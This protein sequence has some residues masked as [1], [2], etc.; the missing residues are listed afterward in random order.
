MLRTSLERLF[1]GWRRR[2]DATALAKVFDR[3][4]PEL[5]KLAVHLVRDPVEA[6]DVLQATY[7]TAIE[8]AEHYDKDRPL[9]PWLV[10]ILVNQ[11]RTVRKKKG[12]AD[13]GG[14]AL[15]LDPP[16]SAEGPGQRAAAEEFST[17]LVKALE[18]LPAPYREV[19][20]MHLNEGHKPVEIARQ[21]GRAPGTVRMQM[22]RGMTL[23]RRALPASFAAGAA[24]SGFPTR[25]MP[26]IRAEVL[27]RGEALVPATAAAGGGATLA[28]SMA[29]KV[30]A[31]GLV[32]SALGLWLGWPGSADEPLT[33]AE[34]RTRTDEAAATAPLVE[35]AESTRRD[36][37]GAN[38]TAS[39]TADTATATRERIVLRG[40]VVGLAAADSADVQLEVRGVARFQ[41][42]DDVVAKGSTRA[43][44]SFEIDVTSL[45]RAVEG[46]LPLHGLVVTAE[47]ALYLP[48][49][50]NV[51]LAPGVRE[52]E[53][54]IELSPAGV[55]RG[56]LQL[57]ASAPEVRVAAL[58]LVDG[59]PSAPVVSEVTCGPDGSFALRVRERGE[60]VVVALA[61]GLRPLTLRAAVAPGSVRE[62]VTAPLATGAVLE[63][64]VLV[65]GE[66]ARGAR[67]AARSAKAGRERMVLGR[68]LVW[69][70]EHFERRSVRARTSADGRFVLD[71]LAPGAHTV[72]LV[73]LDDAISIP[74]EIE[75]WVDALAPDSGVVL[76]LDLARVELQVA[77]SRGDPLGGR[78]L[79]EQGDLL[80]RQDLDGDGHAG[81][82]VR[83]GL[84]CKIRIES[85]LH[86]PAELTL[87]A[88]AAGGAHLERV[89]MVSES[90]RATLELAFDPPVELDAIVVEL[91]PVHDQ[92]SDEERDAGTSFQRR[93]E[94]VD[95]VAR[96]DLVA[97]VYDVEVFVGSHYEHHQSYYLPLQR[98]LVLPAGGLRRE[99]LTP[100]TGGRLR[101][102]ASAPNGS[103]LPAGCVVRDSSQKELAVRFL[104]WRPERVHNRAGRLWSQGPNE[105]YPNLPAG[106]YQVELSHPGHETETRW[107][108]VETGAVTDVEVSL[109]PENER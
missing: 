10:G 27:A 36:A 3:T 21:L 83:P 61:D 51:A 96:L 84:A 17:A 32:A 98:R 50:A 76:A 72:E 69:T 64:V 34:R 63:G 20:Q 53:T 80:V 77:D 104:A 7:L 93:L 39:D 94:V 52:Y 41:W 55:I 62:L 9:V 47:H 54:E 99:I 65:G 88:P 89:T 6:E 90:V 4:S 101:L 25:G 45:A 24:L 44:A 71:G 59:S 57:S 40:R 13:E 11:A 56:R 16:E 19:L 106:D 1:D 46:R 87:D 66:P 22:H 35:A 31:I 23:L 103:Y 107:V 102:V 74:R 18:S 73:E 79:L 92:A 26:T 75:S 2:G 8:R 58:R 38:E 108:R 91:R 14:H 105:T 42:P 15:E 5:W 37:V 12:R 29:L 97:G 30:T 100:S 43:D 60:H 86:R 85:D 28:S 68:P 95:R 33:R 70:G 78:V 109:Q 67:V 48:A 82:A 81:L 49:E